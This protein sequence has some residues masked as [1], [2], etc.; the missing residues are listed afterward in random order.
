MC[1]PLKSVSPR[2]GSAFGEGVGTDVSASTFQERNDSSSDTDLEAISGVV[3]V[4]LGKYLV[5][6]SACVTVADFCVKP[7]EIATESTDCN[8]SNGLCWTEGR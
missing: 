6:Q 3:K 4:I 1:P 7:E 8:G 5:P 2:F